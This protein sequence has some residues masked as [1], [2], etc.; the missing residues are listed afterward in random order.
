MWLST[1]KQL[2]EIRICILLAQTEEEL[3]QCADSMKIIEIMDNLEE[4][5]SI[6]SGYIKNNL[7]Y[8]SGESNCIQGNY[9]ID[10]PLGIHVITSVETIGLG[11]NPGE[12]IPGDFEPASG[13]FVSAGSGLNSVT[14]ADGNFVI[15]GV[16]AAL[17]YE[18][19]ETGL[20]EIIE[21]YNICVTAMH[22]LMAGLISANPFALN[23]DQD[24]DGIPDDW[25]TNNGLNPADST[26]AF[27]DADN[28]TLINA[29]E[30][31]YLLNPND[32]DTDDDN[33]GD[34]SEVLGGYYYTYNYPIEQP[35]IFS[36]SPNVG[37]PG[38]TVVITGEGFGDSSSAI[39]VSFNGLS[40]WVGEVTPTTIVTVAPEN[41][42]SGPV[43]VAVD[44]SVSTPQ[45]FY[46]DAT[47]GSFEDITIVD[48]VAYLVDGSGI[49]GLQIFTLTDPEN[50]ALL[51]ACDIPGYPAGIQVKGDKAY[52]IKAAP[53]LTWQ[54]PGTDNGLTIV[55]VSD[56]RN[57]FVLGSFQIKYYDSYNG[58]WNYAPF[59][60]IEVL[61]DKAYVVYQPVE[62]MQRFAMSVIDVSSAS[63]PRLIETVPIPPSVSSWG[64][65]GVAITLQGEHAYMGCEER[66]YY[67]LYPHQLSIVDVAGNPFCPKVVGSV[68]LPG[69]PG[70]ISLRGNYAF[71]P[72]A[73]QGLTVVDVSNISAPVVVATVAANLNAVDIFISGDSAYVAD[74]D[75]GVAVFDISNPLSPTLANSYATPG[76]AKGVIVA[77]NRLYVADGASGLQHFPTAAGDDTTPPTVAGFRPFAASTASIVAPITLQFSELIS[78]AT[79]NSSTFPVSAA[80]DTLPGTYT[81]HEN[82]IT[83]EPLPPFLPAGQTISWSATDGI[84]DWAGNAS[85]PSASSFQTEFIYAPISQLSIAGQP[86]KVWVHND[87]AYVAFHNG[88]D[89][90]ASGGLQIFDVSNPLL[91]QELGSLQMEGGAIDVAVNNDTA[92]LSFRKKANMYDEWRNFLASVDVSDPG[93]PAL[94]DTLDLSFWDHNNGWQAALYHIALR[95]D[96]LYAA[97][98]HGLGKHNFAIVDISNSSDLNIICK[99]NYQYGSQNIYNKGIAF[100]GRYAYLIGIT[101]QNDGMLTILD[102]TTDSL[103]PER[104]GYK[105]LPHT[106]GYPFINGSH[107]GIE[108]R[109]AELTVACGDSGLKIFDITDP[110]TPALSGSALFCGPA[111]GLDAAAQQAFVAD[112]TCGFND[113]DI[114]NPGSLPKITHCTNRGAEAVF[115]YGKYAYVCDRAG[116]VQ[117]IPI[118]PG[119]DAAN[120]TVVSINPLNGVSAPHNTPITATFSETIDPASINST[121]F[122][123]NVGGQTI[124]G[125]Y[126]IQNDKATFEPDYF[127]PANQTVNVVLNTGIKDIAGNPLGSDISSSFTSTFVPSIL[128][129]IES[130]S[131]A[132]AVFE[133]DDTLFVG[134]DYGFQIYN[135]TDPL[136]PTLVGSIDSIGVVQCIEVVNQYAYVAKLGRDAYGHLS[137]PRNGLSIIDLSNP[138]APA[139]IAHWTVGPFDGEYVGIYDLR[140]IGDYLFAVC[141][142]IQNFSYDFLVFDISNPSTPALEVTLQSQS[143]WANYGMEIVGNLAYIFGWGTWFEI[144]DIS[145]PLSPAS[146]S[147]FRF[148]TQYQPAQ[149]RYGVEISGDYAFLAASDSGLVILDVSDSTTISQVASLNIGG[150]ARD[151]AMAGDSVYVANSNA[152]LAGVDA[153]NLN[154]LNIFHVVHTPGEP[155]A[156]ALSARLAYVADGA[157]G[158]QIIMLNP[159]VTATTL[160]RFGLLK[161]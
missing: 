105:R 154:S 119:E 14:G 32:P 64:V 102:A 60:D 71:V 57:P 127:Y 78:P 153:T 34:Y 97:A 106:T 72:T 148:T 149:N 17:L 107:H 140:V 156:V 70:E 155:A 146:L 134:A 142:G 61:G 9:D 161:K 150:N 39:T 147:S 68:T 30:Y 48:T 21:V 18:V 113:V 90:G 109:G 46:L 7:M 69:K 94:L 4:L 118:I 41:V 33:I 51:G 110:L 80:S 82:L 132:S 125:R 44:G 53:G 24:N 139:E 131:D 114:S 56:P 143:T 92:Y 15:S 49:A 83:F 22:P 88:F 11:I 27:A 10:D 120:P 79:I 63:N 52:I 111:Y 135:V 141:P 115:I 91:P 145:D 37:A 38:D 137:D 96:K 121:T 16:P 81:I 28:D 55:D 26:D 116:Y 67:G 23:S 29:L 89:Y 3:S 66:D 158:V 1:T 65:S 12:P 138:A 151:L 152:G 84:K 103:K 31:L 95:S 50:P 73:E 85:V 75:A 6:V 47:P 98:E 129:T 36:L 25:E 87:L 43:Y 160:D 42:R 99:E 128:S 77:G 108:A 62:R 100:D 74:G 144:I 45:T 133:R 122:N 117:I 101:A 157:S 124:A 20:Q 86:S 59:C 40:A 5:H 136:S 2:N 104:L 76:S 126:T 159:V 13:Y 112:Y 58:Y 93:S 123:I 19:P 8:M 35:R 130:A 54:P